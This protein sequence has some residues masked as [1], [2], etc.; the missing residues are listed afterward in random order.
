M[1]WYSAAWQERQSV[2]VELNSNGGASR[3][4]AA[5]SVAAW[6]PVRGKS[7]APCRSKTL[8]RLSQPSAVWHDSQLGPRSPA[9]GS[10]W[11]SAHAVGTAEK[12]SDSWH[13]PQASGSCP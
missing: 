13:V 3:W 2:G 9:C 1:P 4:Q 6:A 5:Q 8:R 7:V 12:T 11:Q 10:A